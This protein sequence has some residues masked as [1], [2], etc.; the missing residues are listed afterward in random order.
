MAIYIYIEQSDVPSFA[1]MLEMV[2]TRILFHMG[3]NGPYLGPF[4]TI[5][6]SILLVSMQQGKINIIRQQHYVAFR[7]NSYFGNHEFT[8]GENRSKQVYLVFT[9]GELGAE[10]IT[11]RW[12]CACALTDRMAA[13]IT[14]SIIGDSFTKYIHNN[15]LKVSQINEIDR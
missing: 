2:T 12:S 5:I 4:R 8:S 10:G 11:T 7:T 13:P 6:W 14:S 9:T 1:G 15:R 3:R